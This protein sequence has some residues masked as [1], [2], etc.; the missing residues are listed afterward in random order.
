MKE[1]KQEKKSFACNACLIWYERR[2]FGLANASAT[3]QRSL[4]VILSS[5]NEKCVLFTS[6]KYVFFSNLV[7]ENLRHATDLLHNP[8]S[9]LM[10]LKLSESKFFRLIVTYLGH[11]VNLGR[12]VRESCAFKSLKQNLPLRKRRELLPFLELLNV[13]RRFVYHFAKIAGLLNETIWK[14]I[15]E[16]FDDLTPQQL[17]AFH[18]LV[19]A[20]T[21]API[22]HIPQ[23]RH[24]Y[25][26][27]TDASDYQ[28][29]CVLFQCNEKNTC[30]QI[31]C[32]RQTLQAAKQNYLT[33]GRN[34]LLCFGPSKLFAFTWQ[35]ISLQSFPITILCTGYPGSRNLW[36]A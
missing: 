9:V 35:W 7:V 2:P 12:Q 29:G 4:N 17:G 26:I 36:E 6:L 5:F 28:I 11:V 21:S 33:T 1:N 25:F 10:S 24:Q 31:G 13:Y 3:F 32:F 18:A 22:L 15:L 23:P 14:G 27:D 19:D 20:L 34:V 30:C 16:V 8:H